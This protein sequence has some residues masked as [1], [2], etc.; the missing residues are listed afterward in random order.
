MINFIKKILKK[1]ESENFSIPNTDWDQIE[2]KINEQKS[3]DKNFTESWSKFDSHQQ[4]TWPPVNV[5]VI[6][7][8]KEKSWPVTAWFDPLEADFTSVDDENLVYSDTVFW[9]SIPQLPNL[10][11]DF[12]EGDY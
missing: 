8:R 3:R 4:E 12:R 5:P 1:R 9:T 10:A 6:I 7:V 2:K 11:S